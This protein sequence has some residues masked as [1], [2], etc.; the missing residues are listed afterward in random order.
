MASQY[1]T[2]IIIFTLGLSLV[3]IT[4]SI[5]LSVNEQ[6]RANIAEIEMTRILSL[7]QSQVHRNLLFHT[8]T[9]QTIEQEIELPGLLGQGLRYTIEISNSSDQHDITLRG[10]TMNNEIDQIATISLGSKY[11]IVAQG[12]F[13]STTPF[14]TLHIEKDVD[15]ITIIIS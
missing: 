10:F 3:I 1:I 6:F 12:E 4:N 14:L 11:T 7:I 2:F 9:Q 5:F 15:Y 13:H 8:D